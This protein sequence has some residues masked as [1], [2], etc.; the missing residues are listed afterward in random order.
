[1][2]LSRF[3]LVPGGYRLEFF[4]YGGCIIIASLN[5]D[6]SFSNILFIILTFL[7]FP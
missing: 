1:M 4:R 5:N 2:G 3:A 6:L 7:L